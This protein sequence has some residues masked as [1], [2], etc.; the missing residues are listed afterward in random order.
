MSRNL[1]EQLCWSFKIIV[2]VFICNPFYYLLPLYFHTTNKLR[3]LKIQAILSGFSIAQNI[4][5]DRYSCFFVGGI[6][7]LYECTNILAFNYI[8]S[9]LFICF[10]KHPEKRC[11]KTSVSIRN[12]VIKIAIQ[13]NAK[14]IATIILVI[15]K[16]KLLKICIVFSKIRRVCN[17]RNIF[18]GHYLRNANNFI[19]ILC[20]ICCQGNIL[21]HFFYTSFQFSKVNFW[22]LQNRAIFLSIMKYIQKQFCICTDRRICTELINSITINMIAFNDSMDMWNN[23]LPE[24]STIVL[25]CFHHYSK[26]GKLRCTIIYIKSKQIIAKNFP[27]CLPL[28]ITIFDIDLHQNIKSVDEEMSRTY[29]GVEYSYIL[30]CYSF[31]YNRKFTMLRKNQIF[32]LILQSA[33]RI[34]LNPI[35]THRVINYVTDNPIRSKELS[36]SRNL[37]FLNY[38]TMKRINDIFMLFG[39]V[40]LIE[41]SNYFNLTM[42]CP[43][44]KVIFRNI[45]N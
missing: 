11:H 19:N 35:S 12:A 30:W 31:F 5:T 23:A 36:S 33:V 3:Q 38:F 28:C 7:H 32:K 27:G 34:S 10:N 29:T 18:C 17:N 15:I 39:D 9:K 8:V 1:F 43:N 4:T 13:N 2:A 37:L 24:K 40:V 42:L 26:I 22:H 41:P 44:I 6:F 21:L 16:N 14:Q 20:C 45:F 25:S